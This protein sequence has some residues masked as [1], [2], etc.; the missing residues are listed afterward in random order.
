MCACIYL[1]CAVDTAC[2]CPSSNQSACVVCACLRVYGP[3]CRNRAVIIIIVHY[4][5]SMWARTTVYS[6]LVFAVVLCVPSSILLA[7]GSGRNFWFGDFDVVR[8]SLHNVYLTA[9]W[10]FWFFYIPLLLFAVCVR[11]YS[12][13]RINSSLSKRLMLCKQM[14]FLS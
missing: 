6:Y 5:L 13:L 9:G 11:V 3:R 7:F 4:A 8:F 1:C 14:L 12:C 2:M 10:L